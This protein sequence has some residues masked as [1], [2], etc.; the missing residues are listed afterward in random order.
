MSK[1][2][3]QRL[4]WYHHWAWLVIFQWIAM[5]FMIFFLISPILSYMIMIG[6]LRMPAQEARSWMTIHFLLALAPVSFHFIRSFYHASGAKYDWG[7]WFR[8]G[9]DDFWLRG[10]EKIRVEPLRFLE[11]EESEGV[12]SLEFN[13]GSAVQQLVTP[14][15]KMETILGEGIELENYNPYTYYLKG[16]ENPLRIV[17]IPKPY[18]YETAVKEHRETVQAPYPIP[19]SVSLNVYTLLLEIECEYKGEGIKLS[20]W[21]LSYFAGKVSDIQK[22]LPWMDIDP[23][24]RKQDVEKSIMAWDLGYGT[25]MRLERDAAR[26]MI[27]RLI[28]Q[29]D[30]YV[31]YGEIQFTR[32]AEF[33]ERTFGKK[34]SYGTG[35]LSWFSKHK[36]KLLIIG[37]I[38]GIVVVSWVFIKPWIYPESIQPP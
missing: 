19:S 36:M 6:P 1:E 38:V 30:E 35:I 11:G 10:C 2:E 29:Q 12:P 17:L 28:N 37:A 8:D 9:E 26:S 27:K 20:V 24:S 25:E 14:S 31:N 32:G 3:K 23:E 13:G 18:T 15:S 22:G 7:F 4:K 16:I 34:P 33:Y 21:E 5:F